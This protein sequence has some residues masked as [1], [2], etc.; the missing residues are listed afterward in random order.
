MS[1]KH[2]LWLDLEATGLNTALDEIVEVGVILT[3]AD[4]QVLGT[5]ESVVRPT[6]IGMQRLLAN[7]AVVQMHTA[8]G[9][10]QVLQS[11][12]QLPAVA[13]VEDQLIALLDDAGARGRL[14]LAGSGVSHFD[15]AMLGTQMPRLHAL[16][17]YAQIDVGIIRR[18]FQMW[19]GADLVS[20]NDDKTHRAMDDVRCHLAEGIA[21]RTAF[22]A[23]A[24]LIHTSAPDMDL[25]DTSSYPLLL[26]LTE[27][28]AISTSAATPAQ[29]GTPA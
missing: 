21:Y 22:A 6:E 25:T 11:T 14:L 2:L 4:L 3:T 13:K 24:T 1:I 16:L 8:N 28:L 18:G 10:L 19:A 26:Q 23:I 5:F 17:G 29:T 12:A 20:A 9:L 27:Q 7:E 15:F